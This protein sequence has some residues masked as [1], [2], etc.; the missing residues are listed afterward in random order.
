MKK[1]PVIGHDAMFSFE[2]MHEYFNDIYAFA[3][4]RNCRWPGPEWASVWNYLYHEYVPPFQSGAEQYS[5][6]HWMTFCAADG[7]MPRLPVNTFFYDGR[8]TGDQKAMVSFV[9]RWIRLYRGEGRKWLAHGRQL[10]PPRIE[11]D[12]V[13]YHENFRGRDIDNVKPTV[14]GTAWEA[15]DGT[16]ALMF[17][18]ATGEEQK[19]AYRWRGAWT[20]TAMKPRELR[21][22]TAVK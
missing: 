17:A 22:V 11:C 21:L 12:S 5:R 8:A 10:H 3:D 14:Y 4:Y 19:I 20:R 2:E 18:N 9:E 6:W 16:R 7:Q 13:A 15:A 1:H